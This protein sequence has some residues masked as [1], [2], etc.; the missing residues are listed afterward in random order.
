MKFNSIFLM[1]NIKVLC[2]VMLV[3]YNELTEIFHCDIVLCTYAGFLPHGHFLRPKLLSCQNFEITDTV[4]P[5]IE[6]TCSV[7]NTYLYLEGQGHDL[8]SKLIL[9]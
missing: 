1:F 3:F 5:D 7:H 8:R 6:T 9:Y 4:V 2:P